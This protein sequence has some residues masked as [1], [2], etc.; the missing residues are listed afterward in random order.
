MLAFDNRLWVLGGVDSSL[1]SL[2][3]VWYSQDGVTWTLAT[4]S[5]GWAGRYFHC[6]VALGDQMWV[7]AGTTADSLLNDV[8]SSPDGTTWTCRTWSAGWNQRDIAA[9]VAFDNKVW[10]LGGRSVPGQR[11]D[12]WYSSN[13]SDWTQANAS[14]EWTPRQSQKSVALDN[15]IWIIGGYDTASC[16]DV[17]YSEGIIGVA[18]SEAPSA[19]FRPRSTVVAQHGTYVSSAQTELV[20]KVGQL[21]TRLS[22]GANTLNVTPGVYFAIDKAHSSVSR[23]VVTP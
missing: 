4:A 18:E 23:I 9:S 11:N 3:D 17:W 20:D 1:T 15:K 2:N 12:A 7:F 8:W 6:A 14:A 10:I 13:G 16:N 21:A 5:A 22:S 19:S